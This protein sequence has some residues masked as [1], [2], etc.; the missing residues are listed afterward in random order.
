MPPSAPVTSCL[1]ISGVIDGPRSGGTP[2]A[3]ELH[4]TCH[5]N[6]LTRYGVGKVSNGGGA[7]AAQTAILGAGTL[8]AGGFMYVSH[9][10]TEFTLYF[11]T[12]PHT[13]AYTALRINGDDALELYFDGNVVDRY[14]D[15]HRDG[16]GESWEYTDGW[17][18]RRGGTLPSP[19]WEPSDFY[20][21]GTNALDRGCDTVNDPSCSLPFPAASY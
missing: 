15:P 16:T 5:V 17:G 4:A 7:A 2:K 3:V 19:T 21:S 8:A 20:F 14:G 6:D 12:A 9:E 18:Y 10:T 1:L 11:G 13:V